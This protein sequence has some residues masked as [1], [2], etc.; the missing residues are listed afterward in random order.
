[1]GRNKQ[2]NYI[3]A[4]LAVLQELGGGPISTKT[5]V[6]AAVEKGLVEDGD[7]MYH[8]FTRKIRSSSLFDTSVRGQVKLTEDIDPIMLPP[9]KEEGTDTLRE[10]FPGPTLGEGLSE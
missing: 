1:M 4:G 9:A 2:N 3:E 7:W 5:L 8:H 6:T 10:A